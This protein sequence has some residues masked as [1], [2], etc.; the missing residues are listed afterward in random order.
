MPHRDPGRR[1]EYDNLRKRLKRSGASNPSPAVLPSG[2]RLR[3]A[4]HVLELIEKAA[5]LVE[6][7]TDA[8]AIERGRALA[9][10][11]GVALRTVERPAVFFK[12]E[13]SFAECER[14]V[15]RCQRTI[16]R[17]SGFSGVNRS[18]TANTC[19]GYPVT[20]AQGTGA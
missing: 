3:T 8:R 19:S 17:K 6:G 14:N 11:T 1:R 4:Q 20:S 5:A 16:L 2:F 9:L 18:L 13:G 15:R 12:V 7:D 10:A